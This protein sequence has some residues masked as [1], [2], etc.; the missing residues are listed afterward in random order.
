MNEYKLNQLK[1]SDLITLTY[2]INYGNTETVWS[3]PPTL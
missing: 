2:V 3:L 1:E